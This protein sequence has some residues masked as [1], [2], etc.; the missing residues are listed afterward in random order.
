MDDRVESS[1]PEISSGTIFT[2][3]RRTQAV[4]TVVSVICIFLA[5]EAARWLGIPPVAKVDG[6][7]LAQPQW[8]LAIVATYVILFATVAIGTALAGWTWYFA[9]VFAGSVALVTLSVRCGVM[10][11]VLFD[12]ASRGQGAGIF[13]RLLLEQCL[14]FLAIG[15]IWTFFWRRYLALRPKPKEK[16]DSYNWIG[17]VA[18]QI[19]ATGALIL[20]LSPTD[21]KKQVLL[22]VFAGSL[23]G[24]MLADYL[25]P[26]RTAVTWYWLGP[27][28][29]GAV[30]YAAAYFHAVPWTVGTASG[31]LGNLAHPLP[32]DYA[33]AG[34]MGALL[35]YWMG[36]ER[37]HI[38]FTFRAKSTNPPQSQVPEQK[39]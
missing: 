6:S 14:L 33:G 18:V 34:M 21:A 35:G 36:G 4:V 7:L 27:F 17:A 8:P 5:W 16:D 12:A 3:H 13:L 32:L 25:F 38:G 28:V 10:H 11:F 26:S 22:S 29:V 23:L 24:S 20:L 19:I 39:P 30:G 37:H 15:I 9:G 1:D 31:T 2:A